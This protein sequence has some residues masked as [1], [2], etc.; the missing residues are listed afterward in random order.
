MSQEE[1]EE[2]ARS[3]TRALEAIGG[4]DLVSDASVALNK[5]LR[6]VRE[7]VRA[8]GSSAK[9]SFT[10]K[11]AIE[12]EPNGTVEI[13]PTIQAKTAERKLARGILYLTPGANLS[14]KNPRQL[15]MGLR[16]VPMVNDEA[17][18]VGARRTAPKEV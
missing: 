15:E 18:D 12:V 13:K 17:R 14:A 16:E 5:L 4:G 7:E 3:F 8:R 11:L 2:G 10:L 9:G 6:E 1:Q